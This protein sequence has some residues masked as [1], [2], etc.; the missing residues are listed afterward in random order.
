MNPGSRPPISGGG[1]STASAPSR[2]C[3]AIA[4]GFG[5]LQLYET[6]RDLDPL[7][8]R[9]DFQKLLKELAEKEKAKV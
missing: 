8:D 2:C 3:G 6:D 5:N 7:R 1:S 9:A 4:G